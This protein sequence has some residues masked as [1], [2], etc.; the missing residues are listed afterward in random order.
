MT[1]CRFPAFLVHLRGRVP[2]ND[3]SRRYDTK[4][5]S[6]ATNPARSTGHRTFVDTGELPRCSPRVFAIEQQSTSLPSS[7]LYSISPPLLLSLSHSILLFLPLSRSLST[8][9]RLPPSVSAT[10]SAQV[11]SFVSHP[12]SH[13]LFF[14]FLARPHTFHHANELPSHAENW[15]RVPRG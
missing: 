5:D 4:G 2:R 1:G 10:T 3:R 8:S 7:P 11:S 12:V 14:P 6:P 9:L 13:R 15:H